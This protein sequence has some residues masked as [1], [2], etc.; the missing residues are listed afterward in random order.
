MCTQKMRALSYTKAE[1]ITFPPK[2]DGHTYRRADICVY[3]VASLL[4]IISNY[5]PLLKNKSIY[6][7]C[8]LTSL[9]LKTNG[10][11]KVFK[12]CV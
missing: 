4:K 7:R 12:K 9:K 8:Y 11:I 1:K 6:F 5:I 2:P 3:R 10:G